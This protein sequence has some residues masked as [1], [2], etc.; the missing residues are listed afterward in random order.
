M[1]NTILPQNFVKNNS[2]NIQVIDPKT[3]VPVD[4]VIE[5]YSE[6]CS[7]CIGFE[8]D[9]LTFVKEH[10]D[11]KIKSY[12]CESNINYDKISEVLD[13]DSL[14]IIHFPTI[15][16]FKKNGDCKM[17]DGSRTIKNLKIFTEDFCSSPSLKSSVNLKQVKNSALNPKKKPLKK[18]K[19]ISTEEIYK[20]L[21]NSF[22]K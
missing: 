9:W 12:Q 14:T 19:K 11:P 8:E 22:S 1:K 6:T 4:C 16:V 2:K 5:F 15:I 13:D 3:K 17:F 10:L 7:A 20:M 18:S 21:K